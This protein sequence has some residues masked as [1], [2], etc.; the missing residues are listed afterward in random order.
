MTKLEAALVEL[1]AFLEDGR[2]PYM[3]IGGFA[4]LFWGNAR[5]TRD[6]DITIEVSDEALGDLVGRLAGQFD[7]ADPD[8]LAFARRNHLIRIQTRSAVPV[9]LIVA[10]LPYESTAI[11]RA[12]ETDVAGTSVRLCAPEDLVIHKL[13]SERPQDAVD[14]EGIILRQAR[15]LDRE[16]LGARVQELAA[17]LER[18]EITSFYRSLLKKADS[19]P[20]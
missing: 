16:Y 12:V 1:V 2:I 17:G 9:D 6:L 7:I 10:A 13:A 4:N 20:G 15:R 8:P 19:I 14:V 18:P 11:R 5:F 3:V